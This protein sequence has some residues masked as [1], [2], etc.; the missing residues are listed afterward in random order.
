VDPNR[1]LDLKFGRATTGDVAKVVDL[2]ESAYRGEG[3]RQGWTTEADLLGGQRTDTAEIREIVESLEGR[4]LTAETLVDM[5]GCCQLESRPEG[6]AYLGMLAVAPSHQGRGIGRAILREAERL[7]REELGSRELR[8]MVIRQR[9]DVIRWYARA[10]YRPTGDV[11]PF[12]YSDD[13]KG[14]PTRADLEFVVL[15]KAVGTDRG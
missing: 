9:Q 10:G 6:S 5:V 2:I 15:A 12:P 4:I 13:R 7:A 3:S 8:M 14:I 1:R 11:V